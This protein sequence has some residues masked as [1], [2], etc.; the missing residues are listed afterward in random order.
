MVYKAILL[1]L[2]A[3]GTGEFAVKNLSYQ[4][5]KL[6]STDKTCS[7]AMEICSLVLADSHLSRGRE[8]CSAALTEF[9]EKNYC[10]TGHKTVRTD[11]LHLTGSFSCAGN[12]GVEI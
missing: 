4:K 7:S 9:K 1:G 3:G 10:G 5:T 6:S 8:G 12:T 2:H 11:F